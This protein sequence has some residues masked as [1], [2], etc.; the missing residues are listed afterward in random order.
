MLKPK[1]EALIA[2]PT[3]RENETVWATFPKEFEK[4]PADVLDRRFTIILLMTILLD[5]LSIAYFMA[6]ASRQMSEE[7]ADHFRKI[8]AALERNQAGLEREAKFVDAPLLQELPPEPG[9]NNSTRARSSAGAGRRVA[10]AGGTRKSGGAEDNENSYARSAS[11]GSRSRENIS[12]A[13]SRAGILGLLTGNN[14]EATGRTAKDVL[15][16]NNAQMANLDAALANAGPLRR[17]SAEPGR[18]DVSSGEA[19]EIRGGRST[20]AGG[21]DAHVRGLDKGKARDVQRSG[22]LEVGMAEPLIEEPAED[23]KATGSRDRDAVAAVVTR[24]NS[25]IQFCYQKEVRRNPNLKGKLVVR[26]VI[27]PQGSIAGVNIISS[28]LNNPAIE[29]CIIE[30]L[31]RWDDFGAIDPAKGNTT[32]RQV[33]T[34]GY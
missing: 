33:Y 29:S 4:S 2:S 20:N 18:D 13:A 21:I 23:G 11:S 25:A 16:K 34:F 17:G 19:R 31:K 3:P 24:H 9:T 12:T 7:G 30:R 1:E 10:S 22:G 14:S 32:F 8:A 6:T 5:C 15:D 26:F 28:T 27:T